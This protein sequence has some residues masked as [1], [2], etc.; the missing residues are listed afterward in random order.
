MHVCGREW[1]G[2]VCQMLSTSSTR[3]NFSMLCNASSPVIRSVRVESNCRRRTGSR[4][5]VVVPHCYDRAD[6][7]TAGEEG[8]CTQPKSAFGPSLRSESDCRSPRPFES[9]PNTH[10]PNLTCPLTACALFSTIYN[11]VVLDLNL[12]TR[13]DG[14][15]Y[16]D[17][18]QHGAVAQVKRRVARH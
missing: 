10:L 15:R 7:D 18:V 16:H 1:F 14:L 5:R 12:Q 8:C 11:T 6:E 13:S 4:E 3:L 17:S 2:A 9:L